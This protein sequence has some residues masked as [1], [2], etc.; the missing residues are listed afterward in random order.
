MKNS[1]PK[2]TLQ[3]RTMLRLYQINI[4]PDAS[5]RTA[6]VRFMGV[7]ETPG[8]WMHKWLQT[9]GELDQIPE[10][11][12]DYLDYEDLADDWQNSGDV[13]FAQDK[14]QVWVFSTH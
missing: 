11:L 14:G 5:F 6:T 1:N 4:D 7:A 12:R 9:T 3:D 13:H 8:Q 2:M 10:H